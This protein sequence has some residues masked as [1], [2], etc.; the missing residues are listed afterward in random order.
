MMT[1]TFSEKM[2]RICF[3]IIIKIEETGIA[4]KR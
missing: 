3:H 4:N 2:L 1:N